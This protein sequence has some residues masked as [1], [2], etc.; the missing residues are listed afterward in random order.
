MELGRKQEKEKKLANAG[1]R[2]M[3]HKIKCTT[4]GDIQNDVLKK[5]IRK[6]NHK[7]LRKEDGGKSNGESFQIRSLDGRPR[8][9]GDRADTMHGK[10]HIFMAFLRWC[11]LRIKGIRRC[12]LS[13][14]GVGFAQGRGANRTNPLGNGK[15]GVRESRKPGN[16]T[17]PLSFLQEVNK[18]SKLHAAIEGIRGGE[19][20]LSGSFRR[21]SISAPR[22]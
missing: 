14:R 8:F 12:G 11:F 5:K 15:V 9:P 2:D 10:G 19:P 16:T 6:Y 21:S 18:E 3:V 7:K 22:I 17:A 1:I 4:D 13:I 20:T